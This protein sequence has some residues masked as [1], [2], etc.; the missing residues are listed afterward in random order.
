M[1]APQK[2]RLNDLAER[3]AKAKPAVAAIPNI[4]PADELSAVREEIAILEKRK[5]ELRDILL[6]EGADL[7]GDQYTAVLQPGTRETLDKKALIETYGEKAIAPFVKK[8]EFKT[9]KLVAKE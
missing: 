2:T 4:H 9:V 5:D 3:L 1:S 8:T 6:A 7:N